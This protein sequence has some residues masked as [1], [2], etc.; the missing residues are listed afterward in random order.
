VFQR[1]RQRAGCEL[2]ELTFEVNGKMT[3]Y[4]RIGPMKHTRLGCL[5]VLIC[6][7]AAGQPALGDGGWLSQSI[8]IQEGWNLIWVGIDPIPGD[9]GY[10]A[11]IDRL[12][13][14][15]VVRSG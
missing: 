13:K 4:L 10:G 12:R 15:L 11:A 8:S 1:R 2:H 6:G 7:M 14:H 5:I 9:P 3:G